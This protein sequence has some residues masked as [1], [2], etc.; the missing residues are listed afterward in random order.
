MK[1]YLK[2]S[3]LKY[4]HF[5]LH[6]SDQSEKDSMI[7]DFQEIFNLKKKEKGHIKAV[8]WYFSQILLSIPSL[9][10]WVTYNR[11]GLV[12]KY[13]KFSLRNVRRQK[14]LSLINVSCLTSGIICFFLIALYVFDETNYESHNPNSEHV[15][16]LAHELQESEGVTRSALSAAVWG[17][18]FLQNFGEI[19]EY[20]RVK[21]S[22]TKTLL[23]YKE[24]RLFFNNFAWADNKYFDLF[25][26]PVIKGTAGNVLNEPASV[27]ISENVAKVF[28]GDDEPI[29]KIIFYGN[30]FPLTVTGVMKEDYGNSHINFDIVGSFKT[31]ENT[32][33]KG[34]FNPLQDWFEYEYYTYFSIMEGV[35]PEEFESRLTG[36]L[37]S[38]VGDDL[39]ASNIKIRML[40]QPIR[41]IHLH[42][43]LE[44]EL[45]IN[46]S[47]TRV[48]LLA[49][50]GFFILLIA[51]LNFINSTIANNLNNAKNFGVRKA[52]GA[53]KQHF[54]FQSFSES[55]IYIIISLVLSILVIVMILPLFSEL[56]G[57][58]F[59]LRDLIEVKTVGSTLIIVFVL[60]L[61]TG[62]Y[63]LYLFGSF[64]ILKSIR[65]SGINFKERKFYRELLIVIQFAV[66]IMLISST[67]MI[68]RQYSFLK[69]K[70]PGFKK[71]N[72]LVIPLV[73]TRSRIFSNRMKQQIAVIPEVINVGLAA[74]VPGGKTDDKKLVKTLDRDL[75]GTHVMQRM[76]IGY[77]LV[78]ALGLEIVAGRNFTRSMNTDRQNFLLNESA[79]KKLGFSTY[80]EAI[81]SPI[82][83][84]GS[85]RGK[86][87]GI[88][89]DFHIESLHHTIEPMVFYMDMGKFL[90][91][92]FM[93]ENTSG[94]IN[95]IKEKWESILPDIPCDYYLL[96]EQ[97][98]SLYKSEEN[99]GKIL[100]YFSVIALFTSSFGLY[101]LSLITIEQRRK[102]IGI[103]KTLGASN[104][105]ILNLLNREYLRTIMISILVAL[106]AVFILM[107]IWLQNFAY[108]TKINSLSFIIAALISLL[109][110]FITVSMR[111]LKAATANPVDSIRYE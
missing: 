14:S 61:I 67:D 57:R 9:I 54:L 99:L 63:P 52:V 96:N 80:N 107:N 17:P 85:R 95:S 51:F 97:L 109:I 15:Y 87:I 18:A 5:F 40:L 4:R 72:V 8:M 58:N 103:R 38:I 111:S 36:Y 6:C 105:R 84:G 23:K 75:N 86:I 59:S 43:D 93:S 35:Q 19:K 94:A 70:D 49:G 100:M 34:A 104:G 60:G 55:F 46:G 13:L 62:S 26:I 12:L 65:G 2:N 82:Q 27:V 3:K 47:I 30:S 42:S 92:R 33:G 88:V 21:P 74:S 32:S 10:K 76:K 108:R 101:G 41:D 79:L 89:K 91:I 28:F 83:V 106:P 16:R 37:S 1:K 45:G 81:D 20:V 44:F 53:G 90:F 25:A 48:Y 68:F 24:K 66:T 22:F 31:L 78:P 64:D 50:S 110:T 69:S 77:E 71:E 7:G 39:N 11:T 56:I 73:E 98:D 29:G 102:E